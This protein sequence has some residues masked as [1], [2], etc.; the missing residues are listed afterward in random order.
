VIPVVIP[1]LSVVIP[2]VIPI[3]SVVIAGR[4]SNCEWHVSGS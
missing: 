4:W 1:I 2:V 3:L